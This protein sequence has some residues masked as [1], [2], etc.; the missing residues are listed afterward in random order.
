MLMH[1]LRLACFI[2]LLWVVSGPAQ[3][4]VFSEAPAWIVPRLRDGGYVMFRV[5]MARHTRSGLLQFRSTRRYGLSA[6]AQRRGSCGG[7][8]DWWR[9]ARK[10]KIPVG[11]VR[12]AVSSARSAT[13]VPALA[14]A[15]CPVDG[16]QRP[17]AGLLRTPKR[18]NRR[19]AALRTWPRCAGVPALTS[20]HNL[21]SPT[22][23]D[24]FGRTGSTS[25][26]ASP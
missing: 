5:A 8:V 3:N 4:S 11:K 16:R 18:N 6:P 20:S 25:A 1:S 22:I 21:T 23:V 26:K 12:P 7:Q 10:L 19:T 14:S 13:G 2:T 9:R 24:A 17:R 15:R